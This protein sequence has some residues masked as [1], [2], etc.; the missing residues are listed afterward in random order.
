MIHEV[1]SLEEKLKSMRNFFISGETMGYEFR[2]NQLKKLKEAIN[3]YEP[4]LFEALQKDLKKNKEESYATETGLAIAEISFALKNLQQWMKP[5][6]VKTNL[7]NFPSSSKIF[8]DPLGV[9]LII[10]SWNYPFLLL[11]TPLVGAIAGGNCA[12]L[13]PSEFAPATASVIEKMMKATFPSEYIRVVTGAG[14]VVVPELM[15]S[16]N[17][18][19]IFYTGSAKVGKLIYTAAAEKLI[20]VTLELGGKSPAIVEEDADLKT[21]ARRIVLGKF[22]NAGQTCVAP[23]YLLVHQSI[24]EELISEIKKAILQFFTAD[25]STSYNYGKII[26]ENRFDILSGY[27]EAGATIVYGGRND[28]S[29][30]FI[31]PTII[32]GVEM[33]NPLM[34]EEI[35]GP[36]LPV[37]GFNSQEEALALILQ[38]EKPLSFYL[39]TKS[40]KREDWWL[41]RVSFGGGCINNTIWHLSNPNLPFGGIGGSGMGAYHGKKSFTTFTHEKSVM[42]TPFWFDPNKKYPPFNGK[43]NLFKRFIK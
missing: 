8:H 39:F 17:F 2:I 20:P 12:V 4:E 1:A 26:N 24:K 27:L 9:T 43:L 22:L 36:I 21:S 31:E 40:K 37:I 33:D 19:H 32:D 15:N 30:L 5:T 38:N 6:K 16:F 34:K 42:K 35:F 25:A 10:G 28:R 7:L 11:I 18:D 13:K 29:K 3:H 14:A 41:K 23:D